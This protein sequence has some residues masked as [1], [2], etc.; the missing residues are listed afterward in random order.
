MAF[1]KL[2]GI[3]SARPVRYRGEQVFKVLLF[4]G[5]EFFG[6]LVVLSPGNTKWYWF[7]VAV[8]SV[9][10]FMLTIA[11]DGADM[12]VVI[13]LLNAYSGLAVAA[14]GFI[15]S[16]SVLNISDSLVEASGIILK[17]I[18]CRAINRSLPNV[19]FG[20]VGAP[21][22]TVP[23]EDMYTGKV[24]STSAEEVAMILKSSRRVI[25][26]PGYGIVVLK[27]QHL[28]RVIYQ[29]L[30][31][32]SIEVEFAIHPV[33]GRMH[34]HMKVLLAEENIPYDRIKELEVINP[35]F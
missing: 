16:N 3:V 30:E 6:V 22:N 25:F 7:L 1:R 33:A 14:T 32:D 17:R 13:A 28:V 29:L 34:G 2:Q 31:A 15:L 8:S 11:I 10:G 9:L 18:M 20:G 24:T 19:L 4:L 23:E 26:V 35:T 12:P 27:A 21:V 5:A